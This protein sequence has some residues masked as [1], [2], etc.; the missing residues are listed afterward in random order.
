LRRGRVFG[1]GWSLE[2]EPEEDSVGQL[3][4]ALWT[5]RL[6]GVLGD[7]DWSEAF[8]NPNTSTLQSPIL[9][10]LSVNKILKDTEPTDLPVQQATKFEFIID[11]KAAKQMGLTIRTE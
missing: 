1:D 10:F 8:R 6:I 9:P 3:R 7:G 5:D 2:S 11:L 4:A